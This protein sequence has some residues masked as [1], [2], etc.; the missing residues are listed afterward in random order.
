[1]LVRPNKTILVGKV[2]SVRPELDGYGAGVELKVSGNVTELPEDDFLGTKPGEV[3]E[4]YF[5]EPDKLRVGDIVRA[6]VSLSAGPFGERAVIE[7]ITKID[8]AA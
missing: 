1:M 4:L 5:T 8:S 6:Q 2:K 3:V 7:K